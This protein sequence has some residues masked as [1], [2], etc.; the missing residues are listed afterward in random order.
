[1]ASPMKLC[2]L[3]ALLVTCSNV[4]GFGSNRKYLQELFNCIP[5]DFRNCKFPQNQCELVLETGI[6]GCCPVCARLDGQLC[7]LTR[8]RC[9]MGFQC[10][11]DPHA[12]QPLLALLRGNAKCVSFSKIKMFYEK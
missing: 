11:P 12:T 1:M 4:D 5:C 8:G 7:G 10:L 6:C 9:G 3:V 2:V